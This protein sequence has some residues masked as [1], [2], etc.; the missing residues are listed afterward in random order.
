M[1]LEAQISSLSALNEAAKSRAYPQVDYA[2]EVSPQ[3]AL[4]FVKSNPNAILV[5]VRTPPEW[6][7]GEPD[8]SASGKELVK[9]EW[10]LAPT[11]TLNPNFVPE[12]S[13]V[14]PDKNAALFFLCRSGGRSLDAAAAMTQAGYRYC[15]NVTGGFEGASGPQDQRGNSLT[16]WKAANLPWRQRQ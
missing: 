11:Y 5:D 14:A 2:G 10:K 15:F 16:G 1:T 4:E 8:I 12:L 7:A 6:A 9:L 13:K 3:E